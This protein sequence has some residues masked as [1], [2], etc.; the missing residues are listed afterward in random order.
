MNLFGS[1]LFTKK[2]K[3]TLYDFA[4]HGL[5]EL[6]FEDPYIISWDESTG[7]H[8]IGVKKTDEPKQPELTP[9]EIFKAKTLNVPDFSFAVDDAYVE[10]QLKGLQ[11]KL[12]LLGRKPKSKL[13][14]LRPIAGNESAMKGYARA[15]LERMVI[16]LQNRRKIGLYS[17]I[18]N[19]WPH[20]TNEAIRKLMSTQKH[21]EAAPATSMVPDLPN[22]AIDAMQ[23]YTDM[24]S[25]LCGRKPVFYL[26]KPKARRAEVDKKRDP[27]LIAQS[28]FGM[29][30]QILGAWDEEVVFLDEL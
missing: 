23:E 15:E 30:W 28:P 1:S 16:T 18:V 26:I 10:D 3:P 29:F 6:N 14:G 20:T 2:N 27:I 5:L 9:K 8:N 21:L 4:Q 19:K 11:N 17:D 13:H 24:T 12:D 25:A 22:E 7:A